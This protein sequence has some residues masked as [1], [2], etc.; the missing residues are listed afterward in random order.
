M[1]LAKVLLTDI[2]NDA[3]PSSAALDHYQD[4]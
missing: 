4:L 1:R 2:C 3:I